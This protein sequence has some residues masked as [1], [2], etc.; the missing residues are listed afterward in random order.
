MTLPEV[1]LWQRLRARPEGLKFRRQHPVG[2]FV[3]D[4]Y[5]ASAR[6]VIEVDGRIHD[7]AQVAEHDSVR[8]ATIELAGHRVVRIAAQDV[9][10]DADRVADSIVALAARPLHQPVAGPPPRA[11]EEQE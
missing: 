7:D 9:L 1:L 5:C 4:F 3:A 6:L 10:H 2:R 11:G 8:T